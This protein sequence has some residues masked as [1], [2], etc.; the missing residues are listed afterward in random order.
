MIKRLVFFCCAAMLCYSSMLWAANYLCPAANQI[1]P[2][3]VGVYTR[4][5]INGEQ[6]L[7]YKYNKMKSQAPFQYV[8]FLTAS[9]SGPVAGKVVGM[10][11]LTNNPTGPLRGIRADLMFTPAYYNACY[12][13]QAGVIPPAVM[14]Q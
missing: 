7:I 9:G 6:W 10:R 12:V 5:N 14:C 1:P 4:V 8:V 3:K 2:V 13:S 11:C